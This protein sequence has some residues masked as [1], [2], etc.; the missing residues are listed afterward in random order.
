MLFK[1]KLSIIKAYFKHILKDELQ[2]TEAAKSAPWNL[3]RYLDRD[4]VYLKFLSVVEECNNVQFAVM[5]FAMKGDHIDLIHCSSG[6][7][8]SFDIS[9]I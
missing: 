6:H 5:L 1:C 8:L 7:A 9:S 4:L 3:R 2:G